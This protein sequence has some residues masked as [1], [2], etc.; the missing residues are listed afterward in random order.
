MEIFSLDKLCDSVVKLSDEE[1][2]VAL[3][4]NEDTLL[5][6]LANTTKDPFE[7]EGILIILHFRNKGMQYSWEKFQESDEKECVVMK[8]KY[9]PV[10]VEKISTM[11]S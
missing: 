1:R 3:H 11:V 6:H 9:K 5:I 2:L 8:A 10:C 4:N 7:R